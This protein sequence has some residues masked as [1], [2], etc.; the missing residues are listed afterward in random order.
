M[1]SGMRYHPVTPME[2]AP[3]RLIERQGRGKAALIAWPI[4]ARG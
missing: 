4:V 2:D 3:G 1:S